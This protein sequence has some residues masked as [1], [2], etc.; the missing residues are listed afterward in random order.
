MPG[1]YM[2]LMAACMW[3]PRW[4]GCV[5]FSNILNI[6]QTVVTKNYVI[7]HEKILEELHIYKKNPKKPS[8][9]RQKL[10]D[11]MQQQ[12]VM[13]EEQDKTVKGKKK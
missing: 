12:Q 4:S 7:D 5:L 8:A 10:N 1:A 3:L 2:R 6:G 11:A 13:K 9:F